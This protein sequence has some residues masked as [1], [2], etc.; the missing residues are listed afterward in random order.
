MDKSGICATTC[1]IA[2]QWLIVFIWFRVKA[3][4]THRFLVVGDG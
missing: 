4:V 3:Q 2:A 1:T